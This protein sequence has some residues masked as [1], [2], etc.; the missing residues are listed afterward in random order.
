MP[1]DYNGGTVTAQFI[2]VANSASG[3]S[4]NWAI[5]AVSRADNENLDAAFGTQQNV[6]DAN[7]TTAYNLNISDVSSPLT[8]AGTP[9]AGELVN[10][11]IFRSSGLAADTLAATARLIAVVINYTRS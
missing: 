1:A 11:R 4:V 6:V 7:K 10:W 9:A 3:N 5:Q 2:W 8:I